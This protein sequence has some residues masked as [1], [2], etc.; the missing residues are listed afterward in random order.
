VYFFALFVAT[1]SVYGEQA[2]VYGGVYMVG[3]G[4]EGYF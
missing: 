3:A 1:T 4:G 2:I